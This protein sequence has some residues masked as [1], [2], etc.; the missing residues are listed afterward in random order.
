MLLFLTTAENIL[1]IPTN[2]CTNNSAEQEPIKRLYLVICQPKPA[3]WKDK[4]QDA[5][6]EDYTDTTGGNP[7]APYK[8]SMLNR[9]A[10]L[11]E[12]VILFSL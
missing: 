11:L 3:C 2:K 1:H 4:V 10:P 6:N 5:G 8:Y 12:K 9:I 7:Y